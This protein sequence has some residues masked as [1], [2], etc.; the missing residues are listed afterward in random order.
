M[1]A[2]QSVRLGAWAWGPYGHLPQCQPANKLR[3]TSDPWEGEGSRAPTWAEFP[4]TPTYTYVPLRTRTYT[5]VHVCTRT[6][7]NV[8]ICTRT[9]AH[10]HIRTR[11]YARTCT[12]TYVRVPWDSP[13]PGTPLT[14]GSEFFFFC[15]LAG[16]GSSLAWM[17][18][19][20]GRPCLAMPLLSGVSVKLLH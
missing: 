17:A 3:K 1:Y 6:Y 4:G 2:R 8:H 11:T 10:V 18:M 5:Y 20:A 7:T 16:W 19:L 9:Y 15:W 13:Q 12:Y 14:R